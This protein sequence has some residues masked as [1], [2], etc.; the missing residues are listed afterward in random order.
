MLVEVVHVVHHVLL[1][2][3]V[4]AIASIPIL[5]LGAT[6]HGVVPVLLG[7]TVVTGSRRIR[8]H[9]LPLAIVLVHI[10]SL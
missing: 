10:D 5:V 2:L 1:F 4:I 7:L 9:K 3:A 6:S 8:Q